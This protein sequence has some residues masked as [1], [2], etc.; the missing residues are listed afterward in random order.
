MAYFRY[1][2]VLTWINYKYSEEKYQAVYLSF[3][4]RMKPRT[5]SYEDE[6]AVS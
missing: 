4:V 6:G 2:A 1:T 5:L 3:K